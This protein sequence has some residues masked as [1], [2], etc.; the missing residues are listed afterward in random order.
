MY[1]YVILKDLESKFVSS[2]HNLHV[3]EVI[4]K[5]LKTAIPKMILNFWLT[6]ESPDIINLVM[7]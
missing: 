6:F 7:R 1:L 4:H 5:V 2:M 3:D